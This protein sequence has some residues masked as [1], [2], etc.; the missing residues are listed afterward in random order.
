MS[1]LNPSTTVVPQ[2]TGMVSPGDVA[3]KVVAA[4]IGLAAILGA[5]L[6]SPAHVVAIETA[7][8]IRYVNNVAG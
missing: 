1:S 7:D 3:A 6:Y 4:P 8:T 2:A 5:G